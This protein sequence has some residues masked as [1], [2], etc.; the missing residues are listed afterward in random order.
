MSPL[1]SICSE[2]FNDWQHKFR[3]TDVRVCELTGDSDAEDHQKAHA[4]NLIITTPEKWDSMT[5]KWRDGNRTI[6]MQTQLICIDEV[7]LLSEANRGATLEAIVSRV[8]TAKQL[9]TQSDRS[10]ASI[11]F[12]AVSA[13]A[14]N[15]A[16]V[17]QWLSVSGFPGKAYR[18]SQED[19]PVKLTQIVKGIRYNSGSPFAFDQ[20]LSR[21]IA[22][23]IT[24]YGCGK[25]ALIFCMTRNSTSK[26]AKEVA[27]MLPAERDQQLVAQRKRTADL[28]RDMELSVLV[29]KG[30]GWHHAGLDRAD[31]DVIEDAFR[32]GLLQALFSTS[33]LAMGVNLPAYMVVLKGV[34]KCCGRSQTMELAETE[35]LQMTGRA[36]RPQF[37]DHGV[38]VILCPERDVMRFQRLMNCEKVLESSLHKSL[39]E[40]M[41]SEIV[42]KTIHNKDVAVQ[43]LKSTFFYI[44]CTKNKQ[45]Y[46][47]SMTAT[48]DQINRHLSTLCI[49]ELNGLTKYGMVSARDDGS[50]IE[51]TEIGRIMA[52]YCVSFETMKTFVS[53]KSQSS[54]SDLLLLICSSSEIKQETMLRQD[55]KKLLFDFHNPKSQ[56]PNVRFNLSH[57]IREVE[58]KVFTIWQMEFSGNSSYE[59]QLTRFRNDILKTLKVGK[60]LVKCLL[61][62]LTLA[63][64]YEVVGARTVRNATL[65]S[66]ILNNGLWENTQHVGRQIRGIGAKYSADL[67][68]DFHP[69]SH[70]LTPFP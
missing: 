14:P 47:L 13:T 6:M 33:T 42:L 28:I 66:Q 64:K 67:V 4:S 27:D 34:H 37:D 10:R 51:A 45:H 44:R 36:G 18:M 21:P 30:I 58:H 5:R 52:H 39:P 29:E 62:I 60:R 11:R 56:R 25:P 50:V 15:I 1:K 7:H 19:R 61:E 26:S 41:N 35:L 32:Q 68:C 2:R 70:T 31:R 17:A 57:K 65:L 59:E 49:K 16:D 40:H 20:I 48:A 43:W 38:A 24:T 3:D 46:G 12:V 54:L 53:A 63:E 8:K 55:E 9:I 23:A 22:E 69:M